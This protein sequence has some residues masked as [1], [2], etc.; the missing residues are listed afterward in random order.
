MEEKKINERRNS[1]SSNRY[2]RTSPHS[3]IISIQSDLHT[4]CD[5]HFFYHTVAAVASGGSNAYV[6][7]YSQ[8]IESVTSQ[9]FT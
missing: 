9:I 3:Y 4:I 6:S 1:T 8:Q 7:M 5:K 2:I